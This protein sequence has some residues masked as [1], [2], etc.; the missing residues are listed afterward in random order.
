MSYYP[1]AM[2]SQE[3]AWLG[4]SLVRRLS[5]SKYAAIWLFDDVLRIEFGTAAGLWWFAGRSL[6]DEQAAKLLGPELRCRAGHSLEIIP[7]V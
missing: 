6:S 2:V 4:P 7:G 3:E 5:R 1:G